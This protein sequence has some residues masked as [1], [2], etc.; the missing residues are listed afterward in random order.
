MGV[1]GEHAEWPHTG[2]LP[3]IGSRGASGASWAWGH[4]L[5]LDWLRHLGPDHTRDCDGD[6]DHDGGLDGVWHDGHR[7]WR[8]SGALC[9]HQLIVLELGG[10]GV[11]GGGGGLPQVPVVPGQQP[12]A[13]PHPG[14]LRV[15]A[16]LRLAAPSTYFLTLMKRTTARMMTTTATSSTMGTMKAGFSVNSRETI[17]DGLCMR[18]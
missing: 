12:P 18:S 4:G 8:H 1:R 9:G 2:D 13:R 10:R 6:R 16:Q 11:G 3:L 17:A 15:G 5:I 14:M 7:G